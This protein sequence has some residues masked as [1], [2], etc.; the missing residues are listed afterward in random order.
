MTAC[1]GCEPMRELLITSLGVVLMIEM[2]SAPKLHVNSSP[3]SGFTVI[4]TGD[5]PTSSRVRSLSF[6]MS[7]T[8]TWPDDEQ[9]TKALVE[10]GSMAMSSG[11]R[12]TVTAERTARRV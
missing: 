6:L 9:E 2:L 12:Q 10:S 5:L 8:A 1:A 4:L 3:P 11:F 7:M